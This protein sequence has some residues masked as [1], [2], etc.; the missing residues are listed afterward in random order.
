M[1]S[2][3]V[4]LALM[5]DVPI[6]LVCE[7]IFVNWYS[8]IRTPEWTSRLKPVN[9][10]SNLST[11]STSSPDHCHGAETSVVETRDKY[12]RTVVSPRG[13]A[14]EQLVPLYSTNARLPPRIQ[15]TLPLRRYC[16]ERN[17]WKVRR[18]KSS[19][20]EVADRQSVD[21]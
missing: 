2:S 8:E 21:P 11:F 6:Q 7:S 4:L 3:K 9:L 15:L 20:I 13:M 5:P 19:R 1:N 18:P 10:L 16:S 14:S 12:R 17:F